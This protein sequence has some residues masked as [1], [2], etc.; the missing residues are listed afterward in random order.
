V[1]LADWR[2]MTGT[3]PTDEFRCAEMP[4]R[5]VCTGVRAALALARPVR[6]C[7][8]TP[9]RLGNRDPSRRPATARHPEPPSIGVAIDPRRTSYVPGI[10]RGPAPVLPASRLKDQLSSRG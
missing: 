9:R 1:A 10:A 3:L 7:G 2:R 5:A 8:P 6:T 4:E